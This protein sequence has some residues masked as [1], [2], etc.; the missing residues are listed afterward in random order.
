MQFYLKNSVFN[1]LSSTKIS[2]PYCSDCHLIQPWPSLCM[3][4]S[5]Q[6]Y[7]IFFLSSPILFIPKKY[8]TI[9]DDDDGDD[10]YTYLVKVVLCE[11][12][13]EL[14][15]FPKSFA[16]RINR[17]IYARAPEMRAIAGNIYILWIRIYA[18][19]VVHGDA[20]YI[21]LGD[22]KAVHFECDVKHNSTN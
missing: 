11:N 21:R 3:F 7:S 2:K 9:R 12:F 18:I 4:I 1:I 13:A 16:P 5:S 22:F 19:N 8:S 6:L 10:D 20:Q 15:V 14:R 17:N